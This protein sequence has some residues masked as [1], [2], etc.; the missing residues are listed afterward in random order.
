VGL[1]SKEAQQQRD[2]QEGADNA[3]ASWQTQATIPWEAQ[4]QRDKEGS[5]DSV[6][7]SWKTQ[8]TIPWCPPW[9]QYPPNDGT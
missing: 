8:A 2:K 7:A 4:Q 1:R 5:A 9:S 3:N 6:N